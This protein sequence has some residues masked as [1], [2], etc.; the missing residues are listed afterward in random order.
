MEGIVLALFIC[1]ILAVVTKHHL[2]VPVTPFYIIVGI[3]IGKSGLGLVAPDDISRFIT[4]LG[5][6][7]LLFFMGLEI[8]PSRILS[9]QKTFLGSGL[10]D[11]N[12]N[13]VIGF[14][15]A[16]LLDFSLA[17]SLVI[18]SAFFISSTAMTVASLIENRK[19]MMR[20]AETIVWM[21]V[22]EDLVLIIVLTLISSSINSP[23]LFIA[24]I[25]AFFGIFLV[26]ARFG[27]RYVLA[28]M[29]REDE[30]PVIFTFSAVIAVAFFSQQIGIPETLMVIAFGTALAATD[31]A[32]FETQAR[33]FKDVFLVVFF[34]FFGISVDFSGGFPV[35]MIVTISAL[36]I[37]SKFFSGVLIGKVIHHQYS[38]GVEIWANTIG[39]GEFSIALAALYGSV[40]V[41]TIIAAMVIVTSIIGS[42]SARYTDGIQLW[43]GRFIPRRHGK[44]TQNDP[45]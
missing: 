29:N 10:I 2:S 38:S 1:L 41:S 45:E 28:V 5:L 33:P 32:L 30:L 42:F 40:I 20:E 26:I 16:Y 12:I 25:A 13:F 19:L 24:K 21:M 22:F 7:F 43:V 31:P 8:K 4:E 15:A 14:A 35:F 44:D 9:N 23:L 18:A 37:L 17:E 11:L 34:V 3:L 6:I 39:R 36:A 27:K